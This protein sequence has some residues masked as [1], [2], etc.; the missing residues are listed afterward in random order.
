MIKVLHIH[1]LPIISGSG[2]NTFLSMKGMDRNIFKVEL[3]CAPGGR[4][5]DLVRENHMEVNTF[6]NLVQPLNPVKDI[7]AVADLIFFLRKNR[8]HIVHTHNSKAGFVGRLA[9]RI[10]G[11]PVVIHTVHGFA[12]HEQEPL[13]RQSLFRNLERIAFHMCD[14]MIF[15]SQPLVDWA[16][17]EKIVLRRD[18]IEKI[19]SG[20]DLDRF[21]PVTDDE[22]IRIRK[23]WNIGHDDAVIG[24][25]SKL[26]EGKGHEVLIRAFKEIK[27]EIKEARLVIVGEGPLDSMLHELTDRLGL[28]D[29][30]LFTGFQMDVAAIISSFD[31]AVLPSFFEG[32]GRVLLEAMAMEKPVVASRVGGIPDLVKDGINGFLITPGDVKGL[33]EALKKLLNDRVLANIMGKDG[34]KGI[35]DKFSADAM[36]RSIN[37]IYIEC[38]KRKGIEIGN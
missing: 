22:R 29:S 2:L 8:Y 17:K 30:V 3:A 11:T 37:N 1:T 12:F 27:R 34:R 7:L 33:T 21:R 36:V 14:K 4:L 19:Y 20:I 16:L 25:V 24:I 28:T 26:W 9:A 5:I 35:T 32:M 10:A 13:W 6:K 31:V 18:K 15:I 23:K 38:L